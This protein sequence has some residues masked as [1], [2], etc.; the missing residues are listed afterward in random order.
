MKIRFRA[1]LAPLLTASFLALPHVAYATSSVECSGIDASASARILYGAGP[2]P[3]VI[4][5][6]IELND[7]IITT[8]SDELGTFALVAQFLAIDEELRLELMD[9]QAD[10]HL[11]S[12][13][14]VRHND[15]TTETFQIGYMRVG[16]NEPIAVRCDGP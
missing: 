3:H 15:D 13:R 10:Q 7:I 1:A 12:L 8:Q 14:V 4:S 16:Q 9:D 2:V 6:T 11:V 5:A